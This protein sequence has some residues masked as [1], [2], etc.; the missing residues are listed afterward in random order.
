MLTDKSNRSDRA[1][2]WAERELDWPHHLWAVSQMVPYFFALVNVNYASYGIYSL[3]S[4]E[5]LPTEVQSMF[6]EDQHTVR[7]VCGA[8]NSTWSDMFI[9][10]TFRWYGHGQGGLTGITLN[11][12]AT[13]R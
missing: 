12:N 9:E 5:F 8:S 6:L 10:S 13:K 3:R 11:N 1:K 7:H 4:M 2:L